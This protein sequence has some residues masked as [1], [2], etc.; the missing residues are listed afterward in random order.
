MNKKLTFLGLMLAVVLILTALEA[1]LPPFPLLPPQFGRVGLSNVAIMYLVFFVGKKEAVTMVF[2]KALFNL[3]TRGPVSGL[4][5]LS[6]GIISV[7]VILLLWWIFKDKI[8]YVALSIFGA[9]GHNIGQ[10][11]A[12]C[13]ILQQWRLFVFYFPI[14]LIAGTIFGTITGIFLKILIPRLGHLHEGWKT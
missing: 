3:L 1:A 7:V 5:S 10:L 8:S 4:L 6:G 2:L 11:L 13:F 12:A 9:V 14:L